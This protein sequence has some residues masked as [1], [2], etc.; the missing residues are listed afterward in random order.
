MRFTAFPPPPPQPMTL[1][2]A[3]DMPWKALAR[4]V[5]DTRAYFMGERASRRADPRPWTPREDRQ[6]DGC[7]WARAC[8][9]EAIVDSVF[10]HLCTERDVTEPREVICLG[11]LRVDA[12]ALPKRRR[13]AC[14]APCTRSTVRCRCWCSPHMSQECFFEIFGGLFLSGQLCTCTGGSIRRLLLASSHRAGAWWC[15][16]CVVTALLVFALHVHLQT[17]CFCPAYAVEFSRMKVLVMY[18]VMQVSN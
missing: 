14:S 12:F 10:A 7:P 6:D 13:G 16:S 11:W 15:C 4:V 5:V 17:T 8:T 9:D 2:R 1:I 18:I 3:S